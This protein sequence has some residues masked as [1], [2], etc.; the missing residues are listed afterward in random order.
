M[1]L[2]ISQGLFDWNHIFLYIAYSSDISSTVPPI[3]R[4]KFKLNFINQPAGSSPARI[5]LKFRSPREKS[6]EYTN[7]SVNY[8]TVYSD[9]SHY[10]KNASG[11]PYYGTRR[12][13]ALQQIWSV[14]SSHLHSNL[15]FLYWLFQPNNLLYILCFISLPPHILDV[16]RYEWVKISHLTTSQLHL[17][18]ASY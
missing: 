10:Y 2:I 16:V 15:A 4:V 17:A 7:K 6:Y 3:P 1:T 18:I 5:K 13:H 11:S 14:Y 12:N 8:C 9:E